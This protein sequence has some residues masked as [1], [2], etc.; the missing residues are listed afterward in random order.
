MRLYKLYRQD[1]YQGVMA[2]PSPNRYLKA[3]IIGNAMVEKIICNVFREYYIASR[4]VTL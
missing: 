1:S 3:T 2:N 4:T